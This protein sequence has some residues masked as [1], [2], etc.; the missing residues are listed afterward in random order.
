MDLMSISLKLVLISI[1][2][3]QTIASLRL[4]NANECE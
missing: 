2:S 3:V 1:R 4:M